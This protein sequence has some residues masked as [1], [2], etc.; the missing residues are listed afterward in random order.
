[1]SNLVLVDSSYWIR[2]VAL[3]RDPFDELGSHADDFEFAIN[4]IIWAE[5]VRGRV[6]PAIC[7]RFEEGFST[8]VFLN[9][10]AGSW[11]RAAELAWQL[12]RTG[13]VLGL[14]NLAIAVTA[15]ENDA[16]V[17]T[18]DRHF[19]SIPGLLAIDSLD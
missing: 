11:Q 7:A 5:V 10:T 16:A 15:I 17:L 8:L 1:M 12:D 19:Q 2:L 14:P 3:H 18:F 6:D 4:G 13:Q 9:L